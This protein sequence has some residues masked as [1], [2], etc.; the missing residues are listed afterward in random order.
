MSALTDFA[1]KHSEKLLVIS[2]GYGFYDAEMSE[3]RLL[4]RLKSRLELLLLEQERSFPGFKRLFEPEA[5]YAPEEILVLVERVRAGEKQPMP[6]NIE[7]ISFFISDA[8]EAEQ[9]AEDDEWN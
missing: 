1:E 3:Q 7:S 5:M 6:G 4:R 9:E 2:D 8:S